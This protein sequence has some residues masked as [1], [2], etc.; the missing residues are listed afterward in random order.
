MVLDRYQRFG[1]AAGVVGDSS[2]HRQLHQLALCA[3]IYSDHHRV[4]SVA[5]GRY[6]RSAWLLDFSRRIDF[7]AA[8]VR[9]CAGRY[10]IS[11][12]RKTNCTNRGTLMRPLKYWNGTRCCRFLALAKA[13]A[14]KIDSNAFHSSIS[15]V[16][17]EFSRLFFHC[18]FSVKLRRGSAHPEASDGGYENDRFSERPVCLEGY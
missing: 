7:N 18:C 10:R 4:S 12:G 16:S 3:E 8:L 17:Y 2:H 15:T 6:P 13:R 5:C 1:F 9:D 14:P 11:A